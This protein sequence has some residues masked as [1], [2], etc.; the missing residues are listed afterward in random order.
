MTTVDSDGRA[1]SLRWQLRPGPGAWQILTLAGD[2]DENAELEILVPRL[3]GKIEIDLAGIS[4]I[5]SCG[6]RQWMHFLRELGS[7]VELRF[8]RCSPAV[9]NQ[10]NA[11]AN[12]RGDASVTSFL[13]PYVCGT[14][15]ADELRLLVVGVHFS[16][17][18]STLR[19][20][21]EAPIFPCERC[22]GA[23]TLDELPDRYLTFLLEL[24]DPH[25]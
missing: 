2:V 18:P 7:G 9:V 11:I 21:P 13:S 17:A 19:S 10:L 12:F 16:L 1:G 20:L 5:N 15:G 4:R 6:V 24:R 23:M 8:S 25:G 14:C 3:R 22:N